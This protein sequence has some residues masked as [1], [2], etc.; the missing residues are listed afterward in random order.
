M[1]IDCP[2]CAMLEGRTPWARGWR[3][4][5]PNVVAFEPLAPVVPGHLLVIPR[6]HVE[7]AST[8]PATTGHV[9]HYAAALADKLGMT[10]YNLIV[11]YGRA[12]SQTINHLHVHIVPRSEGDGL[13][14]PWTGQH[15]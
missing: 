2:F 11:N 8:S 5:G 12:A 9:C 4:L 14:L 10:A 7:G 15:E 13:R 6:L 3:R 1:T